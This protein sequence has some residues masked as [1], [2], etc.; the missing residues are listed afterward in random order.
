MQSTSISSLIL[1]ITRR[2]NM[3]CEHCIRGEAQ[4]LD[5]NLSIIDK[6]LDSGINF[7]NVTFTGGEPSLYP[8]AL[9]YFVE[10]LKQRGKTIGSFYVKTN[11]KVESLELASA[12]LEL[13]GLCGEPESCILDVSRDQFH[14]RTRDFRFYKGL[15]FYVEDDDKDHRYRDS[16]IINE[17][18]AFDSGWGTRNPEPSQLV[19]NDYD[20]DIITIEMIQIAANGNVCGQC[21]ISFERED[22]ETSGNILTEGLS[23]IIQRAYE[24]S[25][26]EAA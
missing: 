21:D 2:C 20:E 8:E 19:F 3:Q 6:V 5:M 11:G 14:E 26:K 16:Q 23:E 7:G 18:I 1:E 4:A 15:K 25:N 12:L 22:E 9:K 17:G 13:F 10:G 24:C